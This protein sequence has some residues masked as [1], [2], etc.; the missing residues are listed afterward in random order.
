MK[1]CSTAYARTGDFGDHL[2]R[3]P[4]EIKRKNENTPLRCS[5]RVSFGFRP[6]GL[7]VYLPPSSLQLPVKLLHNLPKIVLTH[8]HNPHLT[9]SILLRI[10]GMGGVDHDGLAEL[11]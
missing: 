9:P 6:I 4:G 3:K 1:D 2:T 11:P 7:R 5:L 10:T 8:V